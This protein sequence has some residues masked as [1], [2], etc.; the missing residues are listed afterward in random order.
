MRQVIQTD[1]D[2]KPREF[3]FTLQIVAV[4]IFTFFVSSAEFAV[5]KLSRWVRNSNQNFSFEQRNLRHEARIPKNLKRCFCL[6]RKIAMEK[7]QNDGQSYL[8]PLADGTKSMLTVRAG[9]FQKT[10]SFTSMINFL[11]YLKSLRMILFANIDFPS[12]AQAVSC[13]CFVQINWCQSQDH[14]AFDLL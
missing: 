3:I 7:R 13:E 4:I 10:L 8:N 1:Y 2:L 12:L 6:S 9:K 14:E 5:T 11:R